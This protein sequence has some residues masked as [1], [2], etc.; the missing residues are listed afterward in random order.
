MNATQVLIALLARFGDGEGWCQGR[1]A[2]DAGGQSVLAWDPAARQW[3]LVGA[4]SLLEQ[5]SPRNA[6]GCHEARRRLGRAIGVDR[7]GPWNDA[8]IGYGPVRAAL[9]AALEGPK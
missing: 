3:C 7:L 2:L 4:L 9:L 8:Q 5:Q 6:F 1:C